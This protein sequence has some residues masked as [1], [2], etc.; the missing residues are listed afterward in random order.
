MPS[1]STIQPFELG[2]FG[3]LHSSAELRSALGLRCCSVV[4]ED[5]FRIIVAVYSAEMCYYSEIL[6]S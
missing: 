5:G 1:F 3:I 4:R 2:L 6:V